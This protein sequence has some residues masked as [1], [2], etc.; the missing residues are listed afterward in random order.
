MSET[1]DPVS[2]ED[3][4]QTTAARFLRSSGAAAL[5]Q[6]VRVLTVFGAQLILRRYIPAEDWGLFDW[7]LVVFLVLGAVRDLGLAY[8]VLRVES[9][10]FGN[11]L[12]L[13]CIWGGLVMAGAIFAAPHA[14]GL[15][16]GEHDATVGVLRL[17]ALFLFF[18]GLSMV[19]KMYLEGELQVGRAV[20]PEILR[21][22]CYVGISCGLAI[23]GFGVWSLVIAHTFATAVYC[24]HLW[25]RVW[26]DIPLTYLEGRTLSLL[27]E[28]SPLA[29]IWFLILLTRHIDPIVLGARFP[30]ADVG[31]YTFAY[32]WATIVSTQILLPAIGRVM[33]AAL[34]KLRADSE[35]MFRAFSLST[36]F[37]LA[38][39]VPTALFLFLNAE[40]VVWLVGGGQWVDAPAYLRILCFA[41]L[42]DP[43]TR[44]GGEVLKTL[45]WDRLWIVATVLTVATFGL[46]GFWLT[47]LLGPIGMAWVNLLPLGGILMTW[48]LW[49]VSPSGFRRMLGEMSWAYLAPLPFFAVV[50]WSVGHRPWWCFGL[51]IFAAVVSFVVVVW[52][53]RGEFIAFFRTP[54][55]K[56]GGAAPAT[57]PPE[58]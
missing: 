56:P 30:F 40:L 35:E 54:V 49:K 2:I 48:A 33:F 29:A 10:P 44:L 27:R 5:S 4:R 47:G 11:L 37:V 21:N 22:L 31:N 32:F 3:R 52:R 41:P 20:A 8:H 14:T 19:P 18:E 46:G 50:W 45:H 26:R 1:A 15:F 36:L 55:Q 9:R 25:L 38:I 6:G 7:A 43:L 58:P 42:V 39:E 24:A 17:L 57:S 13:E 23:A 12:A 28:S 16:Q 53:F 51:S 34:V